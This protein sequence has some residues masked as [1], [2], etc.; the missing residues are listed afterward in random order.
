MAT[1]KLYLASDE[2]ACAA[3]ITAVSD[4]GDR[5]LVRLD[6]TLF[7]AQGG[8]QKADRGTIDGFDVVDVRHAEDG[9]VDHF[10]AGAAF[11]P[12]QTVQLA[13]DPAWRDE[14]RRWHSA[15]H[16]LADCVMALDP[17]LTAIR[18][19]HWPGEGRVEFDGDAVGLGMLS[20][21]LSEAL[22]QVIAEDVPFHIVGDP[23]RSRALQIGSNAATPC[24]GTHVSSSRA[25]AGL[26]IRKVQ[27]KEGLLRISYAMG[28]PAP[29]S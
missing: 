1:L 14:S 16:L 25:L 15:G 20:E 12:G 9:E 29:S 7:H 6:R 22:R 23:F 18:G 19:H 27:Q 21:Q 28:D 4:L 11:A 24:G 26:F 3:E 10:I 17:S 5:Q 8:G 2:L 13:V